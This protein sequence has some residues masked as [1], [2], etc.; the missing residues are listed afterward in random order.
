MLL[1]LMLRPLER[2]PTA[3]VNGTD[4]GNLSHVME[5]IMYTKAK[6]LHVDAEDDSASLQCKHGELLQSCTL[7]GC[8]EI[9]ALYQESVEEKR[10]EFID[11]IYAE[12]AKRKRG[13]TKSEFEIVLEQ[14]GVSKREDYELKLPEE[15]S[16]AMAAPEVPRKLFRILFADEMALRAVLQSRSLTLRQ[17]CLL[18][19]YLGTNEELTDY[20]RWNAIGRRLGISG[21]T[22][23]REFR[24]LVEKLLKSESV[25]SEPTCDLKAVHIRGERQLRYYRRQPTQVGEWWRSRWELITDKKVIRE[26]RRNGVPIARL[27]KTPISSSPVNRLFGALIRHFA[28]DSQGEFLLPEDV[29]ESDWEFNVSHARRMLEG[30]KGL[31]GPGSRLEIAKKLVRGASRCGACRSYLIRGFRIGGRKITRAR[32]YCDSTCKMRAE[33]RKVRR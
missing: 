11:R 23:E 32:E 27:R 7:D 20:K 14:P 10:R 30:E 13:K 16:E 26:L 6:I 33:R 18:K 29:S 5:E 24:R 21:K 4:G 19:A 8:V 17:M 2:V 28:S 12:I 1:I 25:S 3:S 15:I 22:V 31:T 9:Y